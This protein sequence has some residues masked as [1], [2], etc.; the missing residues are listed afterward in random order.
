VNVR[1]ALAAEIADRHCTLW[2]KVFN[3]VPNMDRCL[4]HYAPV[5]EAVIE[6][7][8]SERAPMADR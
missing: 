7:M 2:G 3:V 5:I 6:R 8:Q 1:E 4:D